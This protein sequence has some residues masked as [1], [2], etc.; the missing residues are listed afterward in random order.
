MEKVDKEFLDDEELNKLM[1]KDFNIKRLE[2]IKDLYLFCCFTGLAFSDVKSL[3]QEHIVKRI[4]DNGRFCHSFT[5]R[6]YTICNF[7]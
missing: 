2:I 6:N 3:S 7:T 1:V 5:K 4:D